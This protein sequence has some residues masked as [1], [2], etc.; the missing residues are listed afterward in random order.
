MAE[1]TRHRVAA[2]GGL[3]LSFLLLV[4]FRAAVQ[5]QTGEPNLQRIRTADGPVRRAIDQGLERSATFRALVTAVQASRAV[6]YISRVPYLPGKM[7]GCVPL[8][9]DGASSYRY[10]HMSIRSG[11]RQDRMTVVIGHEL[12]HVLEN[13]GAAAAGSGTAPLKLTDMIRVT[14]SQYETQT[15]QAVGQRIAA[16]LRRGDSMDR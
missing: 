2:A 5:A 9:T 15:A 8:E 1:F 11:L 13:L 3:A 16:E 12:Q 4:Q 14:S 10:V 6:V 7:E